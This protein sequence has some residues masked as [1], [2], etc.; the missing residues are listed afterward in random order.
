MKRFMK[1]VKW[2]L[3]LFTSQVL[4]Q[5]PVKF[6]VSPWTAPHLL[7]AWAKPVE[8]ALEAQTGTA[9]Q[10]AS[11][12][13]LQQY[14][15]DA[16]EGRFE[17]LQSP[18][19]LGLYLIRHHDFKPV[20][21]ARAQLKMLV[22]TRQALSINYLAQLKGSSMAVTGRVSMSRLLAKEA[23]VNQLFD[24]H[25]IPERNHWKAMEA[26]QQE[27]VQSAVV[28]NYLYARL[29]PPL[30]KRLKVL[31]E[32]PITLDGLL[33]MPPSSNFKFRSRV[34]AGLKNFKPLKSSLLMGFEK[35]TQPE[36]NKWFVIMDTYVESVNHY[37]SQKDFPK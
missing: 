35:I 30:K 19:H 27:R 11:S 9:Y 23:I 1:P 26:L 28:V 22:V 33:L 4:A 3:L 18:M 29:S 15:L 14:L 12:A 13:S 6:G 10:M 24:V 7:Q 32:F 16:V 37:M 8:E 36:L 25:L 20:L 34:A 5:E 2:V 17:I 31:Y 21:F